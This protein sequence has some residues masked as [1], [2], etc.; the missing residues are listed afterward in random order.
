MRYLYCYYECWH[1]SH[2]LS[3]SSFFFTMWSI[4]L[5][6]NGNCLRYC[7]GTSTWIHALYYTHQGFDGYLHGQGSNSYF[8]NSIS[9]STVDHFDIVSIN[10]LI[11]CT[12]CLM[13]KMWCIWQ[14]WIKCDFIIKQP[15]Q[16][17]SALIESMWKWTI[18]EFKIKMDKLTM[19]RPLMLLYGYCNEVA[20]E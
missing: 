7:Y 19:N 10:T 16:N 17:I 6:M 15:V 1:V 13:T 12:G 2:T 8:V 3:K 20:A 4:V 5:S 14:C 18:V 9:N 11:F